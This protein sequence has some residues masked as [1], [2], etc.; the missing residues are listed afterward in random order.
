MLGKVWLR[1]RDHPPSGSC[2]ATCSTLLCNRALGLKVH[3]CPLLDTWPVHK[4]KYAIFYEMTQS[5]HGRSVYIPAS[6]SVTLPFEL[7]KNTMY[8]VCGCTWGYFKRFMR[9]GIKIACRSRHLFWQLRCQLGSTCPTP[10]CLG[11]AP[12]S[13]FSIQ[14][15]AIVHT[16]VQW[17][18]YLPLSQINKIF[19]NASRSCTISTNLLEICTCW[20]FKYKTMSINLHEQQMPPSVFPPGTRG[21]SW[22]W[23]LSRTSTLSWMFYCL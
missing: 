18:L 13:I 17:V 21:G 16:M 23:G 11:S 8:W 3:K 4:Y 10:K 6:L 5:E 20:N 2:G 19:K 1:G 9:N 15:P 7:K 12:S 22:D 14:L